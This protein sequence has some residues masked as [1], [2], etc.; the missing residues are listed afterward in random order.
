M[1]K[2]ILVVDDEE[3]ILELCRKKLVE[4]GFQT[5]TAGRGEEAVTKAK[6][7]VPDLILMDIILPD[8]DGSEVVQRLKQ[9]ERTQNIPVIFLSGILA[10]GDCPTDGIKV[11]GDFYEVITKPI[12]FSQLLENINRKLNP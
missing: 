2:T 8:I 1:S 9:E 4:S 12:R 5:I 3:E 6:N 10:P 7:N 11:G